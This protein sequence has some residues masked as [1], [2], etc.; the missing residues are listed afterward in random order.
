MANAINGGEL[1]I[2]ILNKIHEKIYLKEKPAELEIKTLSDLA[3]LGKE[4]YIRQITD[5]IANDFKDYLEESLCEQEEKA[6][7]LAE[8]EKYLPQTKIGKETFDVSVEPPVK[9]K[10]EYPTGIEFTDFRTSPL[11]SCSLL[12]QRNKSDQP[13]KVFTSN[14]ESQVQNSPR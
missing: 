14:Q 8:A 9:V 3:D 13:V 11:R 12:T 4:A 6:V 5:Q 7:I 10:K 2:T 1:A